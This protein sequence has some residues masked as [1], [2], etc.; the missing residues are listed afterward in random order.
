MPTLQ[1]TAD[2][3]LSRRIDAVDLKHR[4]SDVETDCRDRLHAG[5][6][7]IATAPAAIT[8]WHLRARGGAVHSIRSGP[9][10]NVD[11]D[12]VHC[13]SG[14]PAFRRFSRKWSRSFWSL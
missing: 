8:Q 14:R 10:R 9:M 11:A 2:D 4:L 13:H 6:P 5:S 3:H 12:V 7:K 1:L